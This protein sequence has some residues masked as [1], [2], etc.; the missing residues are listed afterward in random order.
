[1]PKLD[2]EPAK[3]VE[4]LDGFVNFLETKRNKCLTQEE[5]DRYTTLAYHAKIEAL[6]GRYIRNA[7]LH[8]KLEKLRSLPTGEKE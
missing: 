1:M 2:L 4:F 6:A 3:D 7:G 5:R 8:V